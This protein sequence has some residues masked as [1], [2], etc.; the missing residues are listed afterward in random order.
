[1][2]NKDK[3]IKQVESMVG[4]SFMYM[5]KH[6]TVTGYKDDTTTNKI[7]LQTT[8]RDYTIAYS[9]AD[10]YLKDFIPALNNAVATTEQSQ[11]PAVA[12]QFVVDNKTISTLKDIILNNIE[13]VQ[14]NPGYIPQAQVVNE[15][16]KTLLQLTQTEIDIA[17]LNHILKN[18]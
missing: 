13:A 4:K 17:K 14:K 8:L 6:L 5:A 12:H 15:N 1:M 9:L 2:R 3:L 10:N 18:K 16:V 7:T 11:T